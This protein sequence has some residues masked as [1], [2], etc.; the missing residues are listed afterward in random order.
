MNSYTFQAFGHKNIRA[1]HRTT[2]ELTREGNVTPAGDCIVGVRATFELQR[3]KPFLSKEK[4]KITLCADGM[5]EEIVAAPNPTFTSIK[6]MVIRT[7]GFQSERTFAVY[8]T[9]SAAG[10]RKD[11]K[12]LLC[13]PETVVTVTIT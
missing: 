13:R 8:A 6:E 12:P 3:L 5:K 9:K 7:T 1:A 4:I 10:L 2:L 11:F